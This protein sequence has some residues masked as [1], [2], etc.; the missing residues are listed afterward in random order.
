MF[1]SV[2]RFCY[3]ANDF[4]T[5]I[6]ECHMKEF[7]DFNPQYIYTYGNTHTHK[8]THAQTEIKCSSASYFD[9]FYCVL[10]TFVLLLANK[11]YSIIPKC[12]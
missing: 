12:G 11:L 1:F 2:S 4:Q 5:F 3:P 10:V 7:V 6:P 8:H 9:T